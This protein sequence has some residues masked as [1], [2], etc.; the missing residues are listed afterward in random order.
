MKE[1]TPLEKIHIPSPKPEE[2]YVCTLLDKEFSFRGLKKLLGA[3]DISKAGDRTTGLAAEN[4][5]ERE[6]ARSIL[7]SLT[8]QHIYDSPLTGDNGRV[9]SVMRAGYDIDKAE[10]EKI[11][12]LTLGE[13]KDM[14]LRSDGARIMNI[15]KALTP[16]TAAALAKLM[17]VHE[18]VFIP[19]KIFK[20]TRARTLIGLPK[21]LS[22]RLQ[23]NHPKDNLDAISMLIYTDL[24]MGMGDCLIG[25]NPSD[26]SVDNIGAIL[27]N[28]G[29][30]LNDAGMNKEIMNQFKKYHESIRVPIPVRLCLS[31][32]IGFIFLAGLT[33]MMYPGTGNL[34][35]FFPSLIVVSAFGAVAFLLLSLFYKVSIR[36]SKKWLASSGEKELIL[37]ISG[38]KRGSGSYIRCKNIQA[39]D[40]RSYNVSGFACINPFYPGKGDGGEQ[41]ILL[42]GH[43]GDGI[44]LTYTYETFFSQEKKTQTILFPTNDAQRLLEILNPTSGTKAYQGKPRKISG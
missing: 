33:W 35:A 15:G 10:F 29:L 26:G 11:S 37:R 17:D 4:E 44:L 2:L 31:L 19:R 6:A 1:L 13:L 34:P 22:F 7:S 18:L 42:P 16:V 40:I 3:A 5:M 39:L 27:R 36:I 32:F 14:L 9:D 20:P 8:V 43:N 41:I 21:T 38:I 24:S 30:I 28:H 12:A 25:V 23:P